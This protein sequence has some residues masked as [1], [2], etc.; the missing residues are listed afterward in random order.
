MEKIKQNPWCFFSPFLVLYILLVCLLHK[1]AMEGDEGRYIMF[2]QNLLNGFYSPKEE[3]NLWNGPGY[4]ILL[5][6]F[7]A[8][9]LPLI[10][11]TLF[12]ALLHY[13]SI[14]LLYKTIRI[15]TQHGIALFFSLIWGFYYTS[16]QE[17]PEILTETF[18]LFLITLIAFSLCK[19]FDTGKKQYT[20]TAGLSIGYLVLT[21]VIFSYVLIIAFL[22]FLVVYI[23]K[24]VF[25]SKRFEKLNQLLLILL[26]AFL[27]VLPYLAYTQ[28]LTNRFLYFS[29]SSGMTLYWMSTPFEYEYGDWKDPSLK[30]A[31]QHCLPCQAELLEKNHRSD[32]DYI[33]QFKGLERD[34]AF[35]QIAFQNIKNHPTKYLRNCFANQSRLWFSFPMAYYA[36]RDITLIR[37]LPNTGILT[38]FLLTLFL[39]LYNFKSV[40]TEISFL[41][42]FI[43]LYLGLSTLV[44]AYMR[45]LCPIVPIILLTSAI[46]FN[47][48]I[49]FQLKFR[50][51]N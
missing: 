22:L 47:K 46:F 4:P 45:Q 31:C 11:I 17:M 23:F 12:N 8:L 27:P 38:L 28:S 21:K 1:D 13:T 48:T 40:P 32:F 29:N 41:M 3:L 5:M 7:V 44:T 39:W 36:E 35:K 51:S 16:Y 34:D 30:I 37:F 33:Y 25:K 10:S 42:G 15:Y 26:I 18:T 20:I 2:A 19:T 24:T 49:K 14:V 43:L 6:P 50:L 9:K